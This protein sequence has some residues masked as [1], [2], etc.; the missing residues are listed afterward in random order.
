VLQYR[1]AI[2][3][4]TFSLGA[5]GSLGVFNFVGGPTS[6][7][8]TTSSNFLFIN[9]LE[10]NGNPPYD[11]FNVGSS[12]GNAPGD[13]AYVYRSWGFYASGFDTGIL[14]AGQTLQ[15]PLPIDSLLGAFHGL[16]FA[17][18]QYDANSA[19]LYSTSVS[20]RDLTMRQVAASVPEP[21]TWSLLGV[22]L[23]G[24]W[25]A[26]RRRSRAAGLLSAR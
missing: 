7:T 14:P 2:T 18:S 22:G 5:D 23:A 20:T 10:F 16:S 19:L 21:G 17:Y 6:P 4:A 26:T 15:D 13:P 12:L 11:Q 1:G 8:S 9:D 3:A 25:L 24:I